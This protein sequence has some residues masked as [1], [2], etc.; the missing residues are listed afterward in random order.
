MTGEIGPMEGCVYDVDT[1][2]FK[3]E[4]WAMEAAK[5]RWAIICHPYTDLRV[6]PP[7]QRTEPMIKEVMIMLRSNP[8]IIEEDE[9]DEG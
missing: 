7:W 6:A 3:I 5:R 9:E 1:G 8:D 2:V 4:R